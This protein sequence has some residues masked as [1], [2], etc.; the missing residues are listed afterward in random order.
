MVELIG[1]GARLARNG[2]K[3]ANLRENVD[4]SVPG[5]GRSCERNDTTLAR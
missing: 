3:K 2:S 1:P 5:R 4:P